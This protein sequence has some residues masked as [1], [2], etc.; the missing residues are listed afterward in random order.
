MCVCV[1]LWLLRIVSFQV[2]RVRLLVGVEIRVLLSLLYFQLSRAFGPSFTPLRDSSQSKLDVW[3]FLNRPI[4]CWVTGLFFEPLSKESP[5]VSLCLK[6]RTRVFLRTRTSNSQV[7]P[8]WWD[9]ILVRLGL[10]VLPIKPLSLLVNFTYTTDTGMTGFAWV[11]TDF[12]YT[13]VCVIM[14]R[15]HK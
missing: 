6:G 2:S 3:S 11:R 12:T 8:D 14:W 10:K 15:I 9:E 7:F 5:G 13:G 1:C 4:C